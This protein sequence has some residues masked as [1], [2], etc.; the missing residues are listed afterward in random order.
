MQL[1]ATIVTKAYE[2]IPKLMPQSLYKNKYATGANIPG[3]SRLYAV[4]NLV[5][6]LQT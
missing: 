3:W 5:W 4:P 6:G 1:F 2:Q